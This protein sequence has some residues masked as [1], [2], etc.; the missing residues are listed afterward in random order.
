MSAEWTNAELVRR[1][2]ALKEALEAAPGPQ[3]DEPVRADVDVFIENIAGGSCD[4]YLEAILAA[5]HGRKRALRNVPR[6]YGRR[7]R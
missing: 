3:P 7:E 4:P 1:L 6:P 2:D 5:A